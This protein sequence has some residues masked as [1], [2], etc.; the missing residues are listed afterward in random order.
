MKEKIRLTLKEKLD[1]NEITRYQLSKMTDIQYQTID[2]YYKN[3]VVKYDSYILER[4]CSALKC[5]ISDLI[6]IIEEDKE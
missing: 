1:E 6:F 2:K 5:S 4:F 3:K